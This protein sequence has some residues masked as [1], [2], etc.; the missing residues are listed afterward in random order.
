MPECPT[1]QGLALPMV[2]AWVE[3]EQNRPGGRKGQTPGNHRPPANMAAMNGVMGTVVHGGP[4]PAG[5]GSGTRVAVPP[6]QRSRGWEAQNL[7]GAPS[8][9]WPS[10]GPLRIP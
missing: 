10:Q 7:F 8:W 5:R 6:Q 2:V 3:G 1:R 4:A 9:G